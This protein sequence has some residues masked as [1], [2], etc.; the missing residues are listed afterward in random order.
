MR[1]S[2]VALDRVAV[3][4]L[5]RALDVRQHQVPSALV[6]DEQLVDDFREVA[7]VGGHELRAVG[8]AAVAL[9][10]VVAE[11]DLAHLAVGDDVDAGLPLARHHVDDRLLDASLQL[12]L[13]DRLFIEEIPHHA[14]EIG[15]PRQAAGMR[16]QDAVVAPLHCLPSLR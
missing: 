13:V 4:Q 1:L 11:A 7:E 15:R 3:A 6:L 2:D 8:K 12:R 5:D 14:R 16:G 9:H 10:H